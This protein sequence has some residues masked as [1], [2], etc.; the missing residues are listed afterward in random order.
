M[1]PAYVRWL[2]SKCLGKTAELP[3]PASARLGFFRSFS[4]YW[5]CRFGYGD[6][7]IALLQRIPR[8][9]AV[10]VDAGANIGA[11]TV[12]LGRMLPTTKVFSFEPS[13]RTGKILRCNV[14]LNGLSNVLVNQAAIAD[15]DGFVE[16]I[17]SEIGSA[18]N[19]IAPTKAPEHNGVTVPAI[20]LDSFAAKLNL[21]RIGFIKIDIEGA[22][23]I[24][25]RGAKDLLRNKRIEL[26]LIELCP[27]NL[28]ALGFSMPELFSEI[29]A[30]GYSI[31]T[32][33]P[34][35]TAGRKLSAPDVA[36][37]A[38]WNAVLLPESPPA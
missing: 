3:L 21:E 26:G 10:V 33:N 17:D 37:E 19:H 7:E 9:T 30:R 22:E 32:L 25:I 4:E 15:R 36:P 28:Q 8:S 11:Y 23:V 27:Q 6:S 34:D 12:M 13:L 2:G 31:H 38:C 35:G 14:A 16:F 18:T 5:Q 29:E 1:L 24:A 20:S